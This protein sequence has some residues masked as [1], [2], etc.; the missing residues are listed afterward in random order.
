MMTEKLS[1]KITLT[2]EQKEQ[3]KQETGKNVTGVKLNLEDL[4]ARIAPQIAIN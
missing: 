4:E 2:P 3:L 1:I